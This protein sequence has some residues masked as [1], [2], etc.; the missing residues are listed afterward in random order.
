MLE[1]PYADIT[2]GKPNCFTPEDWMCSSLRSL[3][4]AG[5][6]FASRTI[7][8]CGLRCTEFMHDLVTMACAWQVTR[9]LALNAYLNGEKEPPPPVAAGADAGLTAQVGIPCTT[10]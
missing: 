3:G 10:V 7:Q 2:S 4:D 6:G 5:I 9:L 8:A 1:L